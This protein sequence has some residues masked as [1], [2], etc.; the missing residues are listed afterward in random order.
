MTLSLRIQK[1]MAC[2]AVITNPWLFSRL[3]LCPSWHCLA[4][5][6]RFNLLYAPVRSGSHKELLSERYRRV[7][8]CVDLLS[9]EPLCSRRRRF[10]QIMFAPFAY[11][12]SPLFGPAS[13][14]VCRSHFL[15]PIMFVYSCRDKELWWERRADLGDTIHFFYLSCRLVCPL[16]ITLMNLLT[17]ESN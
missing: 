13:F 11:V 12:Y 10:S 9:P 15:E 14:R 16:N 6:A 5:D 1:K 2:N 17:C 3:V 7:A 8:P 4:G